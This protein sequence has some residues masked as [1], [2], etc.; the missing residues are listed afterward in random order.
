MLQNTTY[1]LESLDGYFILHHPRTAERIKMK[2][3]REI[4]QLFQCGLL[5]S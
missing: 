1:K 4:D 2:F 3:G 5:N